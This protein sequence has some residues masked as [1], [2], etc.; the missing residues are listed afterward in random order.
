MKTTPLLPTW[1]PR[2]KP[3]R[4]RRLYESDAAGLLDPELLDD[5]GWGLHAR[6]QSFIEAGEAR[7]GRIRCPAC[8]NVIETV[9]S[10]RGKVSCEACGWQCPRRDYLN[11]IR[12]QQLDGGPEV[13]ALFQGFYEAFPQAKEPAEKMLL[14][15]QLIH[16]FHHYLT[17]GR[18]RRPV[19]V[20]LIDG[21]LE[22][23][24]DFLD[25]LT[26]GPNSTPGVEQNHTVWQARV[27]TPPSK[28]GKKEV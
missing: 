26:F 3:Y 27:K 9:F 25:G 12:G 1:S 11:T 13:L 23:V 8:R 6:C 19:A 10:S 22:F 17:S 21:P 15:D 16:G 24:I 7:R 28:K 5:V 4:L 14:I 18:T 20:N 2:I